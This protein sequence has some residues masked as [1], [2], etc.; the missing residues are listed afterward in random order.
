[1]HKVI[2]KWC[3]GQGL[4]D[5]WSVLVSIWIDLV[6]FW[7]SGG[8]VKTVLPRVRESYFHSLSVCKAVF[9]DITLSDPALGDTFCRF[10]TILHSMWVPREAK[11]HLL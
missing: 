1:M 11:W 7:R 3:P 4:G 6:T 10:G 8:I 2:W 9:F 5:F